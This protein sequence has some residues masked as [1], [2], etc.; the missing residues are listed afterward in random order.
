MSA[1]PGND[2]V[3]E[4]FRWPSTPLIAD[5]C[6]RLGHG[7]RVAPPSLRAPAEPV[8]LAGG[9]LR[10]RHYGSVD[11]FLEALQA[12]QDGDV[13]VIDNGGRTDE[14]CIGDLVVLEAL[15]AGIA[16]IV[17][18]GYHRDTPDLIEI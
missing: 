5:A 4:T 10:V 12:A 1:I 6:V 15:G 7:L 3:Q 2:V 9:V 11:I 8:R 16:G 13:L 17:V 14:A 18:W